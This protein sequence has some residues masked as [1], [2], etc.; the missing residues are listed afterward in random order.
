MK[1]SFKT[2]DKLIWL[3]YL[4]KFNLKEGVWEME[5]GIQGLLFLKRLAFN[6]G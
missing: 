4:G 6:M 1:F 5:R 3:Y 2:K